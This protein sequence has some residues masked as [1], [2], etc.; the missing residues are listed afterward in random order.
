MRSPLRH[1]VWLCGLLLLLV[2]AAF[3][4]SPEYRPDLAAV[5]DADDWCAQQVSLTD[6]V[7]K[8]FNLDKEE[9]LAVAFPEMTRYTEMS[10]KAETSALELLYTNLGAAYAN[11]SI[12]RFQMKPQ[13]IE[14]LESEAGKRKALAAFGAV[15]GYGSLK[16]PAAIRAERIKRLKNPRWQVL[17][18]ACWYRCMEDIHAQKSWPSKADKVSYFAAAYNCGNWDDDAVI[19]K[20]E[21]TSW[22]PYGASNK[23]GNCCY[24]ALSK[25]RYLERTAH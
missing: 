17:Y 14:R 25:E 21:S 23:S 9:F 11:F 24:A 10:D 7:S 8:K 2:A 18:L 22:F 12:G 3:R 13:F 4:P 6:S 16:E 15:A 1:N 5:A 19:R 20:W